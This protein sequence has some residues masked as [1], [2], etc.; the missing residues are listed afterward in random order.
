MFLWRKID[1]DYVIKSLYIRLGN[2]IIA[3]DEY[4]LIIYYSHTFLSK[5]NSRINRK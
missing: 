5:L 2:D 3:I 4:N 1:L